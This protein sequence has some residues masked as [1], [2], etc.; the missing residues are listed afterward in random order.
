MTTLLKCRSCG[1]SIKVIDKNLRYGSAVCQSCGT[2]KNLG[3]GDKG[4]RLEAVPEG[5]FVERKGAVQHITSNRTR[6]V[7]S[8]INCRE[9][10][11]AFVGTGCV[12]VFLYFSAE[13]EYISFCTLVKIFV[14]GLPVCFCVLTWLLSM[15]LKIAPIRIT[16]NKIYTSIGYPIFVSRKNIKQIYSVVKNFDIH[17][18]S[19]NYETMEQCSVYALLQSSKRVCLITGLPSVQS[20]LYIEEFIELELGLMEKTVYGEAE[21]GNFYARVYGHEGEQDHSLHVE[22]FKDT[23]CDACGASLQVTSEE[24]RRGVVECEYCSSVTMLIRPGEDSSL[25]DAPEA[26]PQ[27]RQFKMKTDGGA[28]RIK[29]YRVESGRL[30]FE[31]TDQN[32]FLK[33]YKIPFSEIR[34]LVVMRHV[35]TK[36]VDSL[37][38][39][40]FLFQLGYSLGYS[41]GA[42]RNAIMLYTIKILL[43]NG[44]KK[45]LLRNILDP[46]E[47]F[48]I[49]RKIDA[50][51][52]TQKRTKTAES[53]YRQL[54]QEE[55]GT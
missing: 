45:V 21:K 1:D 18:T 11:Q 47:A 54:H 5:I 20:A 4:K 23:H 48:S 12:F 40:E 44:K 24:I 51:V 43:K 42:G 53:V 3:V 38:I 2:I 16:K 15:R 35:Q 49:L 19:C 50:L 17:R 26:R 28:D 31:V 33:G 30:L 27:K 55:A 29:L 14:F 9:I 41:D 34:E 25:L 46:Q 37:T 7:S 8:V 36:Q 32:I 13:L 39:R 6:E 22:Q 52:E 10:H